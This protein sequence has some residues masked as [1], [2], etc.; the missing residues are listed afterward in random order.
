MPRSPRGGHVL[1]RTLE[2]RSPREAAIRRSDTEP[3]AAPGLVRGPGGGGLCA[4][5]RLGTACEEA[6]T[7]HGTGRLVWPTGST[8]S[9][10]AGRPPAHVLGLGQ[11]LGRLRLGPP[12]ARRLLV[13]HGLR[14]HEC[15][16]ASSPTR[17]STR[18]LGGT[19]ARS[20]R[21]ALSSAGLRAGPTLHETLSRVDQFGP[22]RSSSPPSHA[23]GGVVSVPF[24]R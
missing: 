20:G 19:R 17:T 13:R 5:S 15:A 21:Q 12:A 8:R 11:L 22:G 2:L 16:A 9:C 1:R 10:R 3:P 6:D 7:A 14:P 24:G 18:S 4:G 23:S